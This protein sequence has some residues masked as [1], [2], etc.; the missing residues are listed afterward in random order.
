MIADLGWDT[1][2]RLKDLD[3]LTEFSLTPNLD[4]FT[5]TFWFRLQLFHKSANR[6]VK[7][8]PFFSGKQHFYSFFQ[9]PSENS[10]LSMMY[11]IIH[12]LVDIPAEPYL[13]QYTSITRGH[14]SRLHQIQTTNST[15]QQSFFPRTI[16]LWNQLHQTAVSQTTLEAF[17]NHTF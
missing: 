12:N 5:P 11:R 6:K 1:L 8:T 14:D 4:Y 7:K 13:T 3:T 9:N 17:Q 10:E 16:T 2:Q 15:Y